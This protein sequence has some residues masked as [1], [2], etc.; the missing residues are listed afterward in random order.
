MLNHFLFDSKFSLNK[1]STVCFVTGNEASDL[2]SMASSVVYAY[3]LETLNKDDNTIYLPLINIPRDD[4]KLRTE[5]VYLFSEAGIQTDNLIFTDEIN[6]EEIAKSGKLKM[7]L[8]DHNKLTGKLEKYSDLVTEV[9]DHHKDE[10][11]YSDDIK[12]IE[13][14]GSTAT[15]IAEKMIEI[16]NN[17][18]DEN[19]ALLL[20]GTI[21][22]DTVNFDPKAKRTTLKDEKTAGYMLENF[23]LDRERLFDKL[24]FEKFNTSSLS[25]EDVL[26]KDYKEWTMGGLKCGFSSALLPAELWLEKDKNITDSVKSYNTQKKLDVLFIM[27]AYTDPEF[28]RE[29]MIFSEDKELR[30]KLIKYLGENNLQL[31]SIQNV[32]LPHTDLMNFFSQGNAAYSRKKL[33]PII[34]LFFDS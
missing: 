21:L 16:N 18:L 22:L 13:P 23:N 25:T 8:V 14:V 11:L 26:R 2:D 24:Q 27:I 17:I 12:T 30:K 28:T 1:K 29:L 19:T 34:Q 32:S 5:A 4:F 9:I 3:L 6:I 7:I 15:L 31:S 20:T 10:N 33:Q